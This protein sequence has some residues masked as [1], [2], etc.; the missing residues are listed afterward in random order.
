MEWITAQEAVTLTGRNKRNIYMW[1]RKGYVQT[2]IVKLNKRQTVGT[3]LFNREDV[4]T[5]GN[6]IGQGSRLDRT[7]IKNYEPNQFAFK[8]A[9]NKKVYV[10]TD[11]QLEI[12]RKALENANI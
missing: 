2:K 10:F 5:V 8:R 7:D 9:D 4:I 3:L 11:K 1:A 6:K 12:A